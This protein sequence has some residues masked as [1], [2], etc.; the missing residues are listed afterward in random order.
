[1]IDTVFLLLAMATDSEWVQLEK[2]VAEAA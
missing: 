1:M 2:E